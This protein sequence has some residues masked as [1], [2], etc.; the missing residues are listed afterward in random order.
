MD[1]NTK[2]LLC[3]LVL[4]DGTIHK[5]GKRF[6]MQHSIKQLEYLKYKVSLLKEVGFNLEIQT[7]ECNGYQECRCGFSND[8]VTRIRKWVY[9][10]GK[11]VIKKEFLLRLTD[12]QMSIINCHYRSS[13]FRQYPIYENGQ[14]IRWKSEIVLTILNKAKDDEFWSDELPR[15]SVGADPKTGIATCPEE[16][17]K[18]TE[19]ENLYINE[20][21]EILNNYE[22]ELDTTELQECLYDNS[23]DL[24]LRYKLLQLV[25]LSI[26]YSK[27]TIPEYGYERAKR[28]INEFN[29]KMNLELST[30]EID[31]IISR[32]Y[33]SE[34][35]NNNVVTKRKTRSL[36]RLLTCR[37]EVQ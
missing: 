29:K 6:Q 13:G 20:L 23:C 14:L 36:I 37:K 28:F 19:K 35:T 18:Y 33:R 24:T 4:G 1:K 7:F 25:A 32:D 30:E 11:K 15:F 16:L 31:E 9:K 21:Y 22:E 8:Y 2:N 34:N 3:G 12:R 26:L 17:I 27:N 5:R 10:T